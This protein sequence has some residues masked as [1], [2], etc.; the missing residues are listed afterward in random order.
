MVSQPVNAEPGLNPS[1]THSASTLRT[2]NPPLHTKPWNQR[3]AEPAHLQM[4]MAGTSCLGQ[5]GG[6]SKMD[7]G[8]E[9]LLSSCSHGPRN[10]T[11][12]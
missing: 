11:A 9:F 10:S 7:S 3:F 1:L 4:G 5:V 8:A 2:R 6:T 12:G